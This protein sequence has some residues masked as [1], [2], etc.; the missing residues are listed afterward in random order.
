MFS[1]FSITGASNGTEQAD[2]AGNVRLTE[3]DFAP[4]EQRLVGSDVL[5]GPRPSRPIP[6]AP[7]F[8]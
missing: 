4:V 7:V 3:A 5:R 2:A 8:A 6:C 1:G